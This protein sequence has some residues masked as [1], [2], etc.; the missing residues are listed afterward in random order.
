M[1]LQVFPNMGFLI[2]S[3]LFFMGM[4]HGCATKPAIRSNQR[5]T[6]KIT[7]KET[8]RT[9]GHDAGR[10]AAAL[11]VKQIGAPYRY[12]GTSPP[13]FDC[14]GLVQYV[15]GKLG[16]DLP[17]MATDMARVGRQVSRDDL[18]PGD[19]LFFRISGDRVS[20]VGIY[21]RGEDFV[22]ATKSGYPVR[23]DSLANPWWLE[24]L[25]VARRVF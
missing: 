3:I 25:V 2:F 19:L 11:A 23:R 22:H 9:S 5:E 1:Q 16:I 14:S 20:H 24:R 8:V 4:L 7:Q 15:Y 21:V 6:R 13:G 18:L 12:G 17:R 10:L